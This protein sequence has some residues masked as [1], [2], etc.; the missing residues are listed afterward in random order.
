MRNFYLLCLFSLFLATQGAAWAQAPP[1]GADPAASAAVGAAKGAAEPDSYEELKKSEFFSFFNLSEVKR[2][3]ADNGDLQIALKTGGF[4]EFIDIQLTVDKNDWAREAVLFIDRSWIGDA[5]RL[6]PFAKDLAKSFISAMTASR[7]RK[8]AKLFTDAIWNLKGTEDHVISLRQEAESSGPL[9]P[10]VSKALDVYAGTQR[11][12]RAPM[13]AT[14]L[15]L[16]NVTADGRDRLRITV[17]RLSRSTPADSSPAAAGGDARAAAGDGSDLAGALRMSSLVFGNR[18]MAIVNKELKA[19]KDDEVKAKLVVSPDEILMSLQLALLFHDSETV[20]LLIHDGTSGHSVLAMGRSQVVDPI[21]YLETWPRGSFLE[22][23]NNQG[24]VAAAPSAE[25]K[26]WLVKADE[27]RRVL[28]AILL[29]LDYLKQIAAFCSLVSQ[30]EAGMVAEYRKRADK[31]PQN[32]PTAEGRLDR[33]GQVF[34][35]HGIK[36][37]ALGTFKLNL[38]L[39]PQSAGA[40]LRLADLYA[41]QGNAALAGMHYQKA[42]ALVGQDAGLKDPDKQR[43]KDAAAQGLSRVR[44]GR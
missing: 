30:D 9:P 6:S 26:F 43:L 42:L 38:E 19:P 14:D 31:E 37:R 11:R 7:D 22:R 1:R 20:Q 29:D 28:Y 17:R 21:E 18:A 34:R 23:G 36:P 13:L 27:L 40:A 24:G 44:G 12:L 41:E 4:R 16:E 35:T 33:L 39:H 3:P 8:Q 15:I 32:Y 10:D 25:R 2:V 5:K